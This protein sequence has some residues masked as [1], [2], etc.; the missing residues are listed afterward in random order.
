M[1]F[2]SAIGRSDVFL[3]SSSSVSGEG[4][5]AFAI[6]VGDSDTRGVGACTS[7]RSSLGLSGGSF[8]VCCVFALPDGQVSGV[9]VQS[10]STAGISSSVGVE[11]GGWARRRCVRTVDVEA[12][13][14]GREEFEGGPRVLGKEAEEEDEEEG[15]GG[16]EGCGVV[17]V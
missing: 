11:E 8:S 10:T 13:R 7:L 12:P 4:V 15:E 1:A 3:L 2:R 17:G 14:E 6:R 5:V 9:A 16:D